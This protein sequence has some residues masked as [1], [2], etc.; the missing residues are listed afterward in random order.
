MQFCDVSLKDHEDYL[1]Q[2]YLPFNLIKSL[3]L[4]KPKRLRRKKRWPCI[5][6]AR[7]R[8]IIMHEK[9]KYS[10]I[11]RFYYPLYL[12]FTSK[13]CL[14]STFWLGLCRG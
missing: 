14:N 11:S 7:L 13:L 2:F 8:E 1:W 9:Q 10:Y 4:L 6:S 3:I 12:L 5:G